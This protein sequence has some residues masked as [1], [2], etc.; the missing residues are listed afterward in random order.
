MLLTAD[1]P[2]PVRVLRPD[3]A[4]D[5]FLTADHAGQA[6]P[7]LLGDL[8]VPA[9]ERARHIGWD[10]GIAG[11]TERLSALLDATAVLQAYS[12]LVIDCNRD[13][14]WASAMPAVSEH[15]PIPGNVGLTSAQRQARVDAIFTPYHD[16][17]RTLLDARASRRT[18]LVAMHSFTP[19]F[20]GESRAMHVG[21]LFYQKTQLAEIMLDLLRQ[22][23]D[24]VVGENAPYAITEN[25]DYSIPTHGSG[26]GLPHVEIE[27]RQD[28]IE[29]AAGQAAWADRFARLLTEANARLPA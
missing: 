23:G 10:I 24:L 14:S 3:G 17:I 1:D 12:R 5:L 16:R 6:I 20:K 21:V 28:L 18:V 2:T 26:R 27:I 7:R 29:T 22:E 13:P 4:S 25:S 15:T 11:V 8:G 9:P 19:R